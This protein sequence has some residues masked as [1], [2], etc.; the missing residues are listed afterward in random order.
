MDKKLEGLLQ[1]IFA[2][3]I[4]ALVLVFSKEI[5]SLGQ[6]GYL[7]AFVISLVS[8]ATL[9]FPAPGW[10]VIIGLSKVLDPLWLGVVAG[11]G[12]GIG[13]ITGYVAGDGV[14][15]IIN[16]KSK[17]KANWL[18]KLFH[19]YR[20]FEM[21]QDIVSKHKMAA[22]FVLAAIPN[23]IFDFAGVIA[24]GL[25]MKW[26]EFLV[27]TIAGRIVRFVILAKLGNWAL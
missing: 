23:P 20:I 25:K 12:S 10:A 6:Y 27:A 17:D 26:Y 13:E 15:D 14:R 5:E 21:L 4:I 9:F 24:G 11:L 1:I 7:G 18:G 2:I 3:I 19:K 8:S 16:D 22:I